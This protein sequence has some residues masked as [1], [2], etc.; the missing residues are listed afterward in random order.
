MLRL[1]VILRQHFHK[2]KAERAERNNKFKVI[3]LVRV[4]DCSA[5]KEGSAEKRGVAAVENL[6]FVIAFIEEIAAVD[7]GE[8]LVSAG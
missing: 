8:G 4:A 2:V 5:G 1:E 6:A 7:T 3:A